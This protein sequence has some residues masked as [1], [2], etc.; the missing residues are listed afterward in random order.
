M[1]SP[2]TRDEFKEYCLRK[3]GKPTIKI[4]VADDQLDDRIDDALKRWQ[5]YHF[6]G[7]ERYYLKHLITEADVETKTIPVD[8][9][10]II[11]VIRCFPISQS[12][13]NMFDVRYQVRLNDFYNFN[14]VSMIHYYMTMTH[15]ALLDFLFN[16]VPPI[17]FNRKD[18]NIYLD[19][20]Q[21]DLCVGQFIVFEAYRA[22]DPQQFN[23][24]WS[25]FW[26]QEYSC[27]LIKR[28]W[29]TNLKKFGKI[30]M[31]GGVELNGQEIYD[32]AEKNIRRL[33]DEIVSK[34]SEPPDFFMG[35]YLIYLLPY[36]IYEC[37]KLIH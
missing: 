19:V 18:R 31:P 7:V 8:D 34:Y 27:E 29:G 10:L 16:M 4:N 30:Q 20:D 28:Q 9:P 37:I 24:V 26:L 13:I 22:V 1:A 14:N 15:L 2:R 5:E 12:T 3:L 33:E 32:E 36:I 25:D 21:S 17:R 23:L 6:D 35:G 11:G